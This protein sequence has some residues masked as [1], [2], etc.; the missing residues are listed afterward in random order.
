[1]PGHVAHSFAPEL[2]HKISREFL[3][4]HSLSATV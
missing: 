3:F 1:M 2:G 4:T